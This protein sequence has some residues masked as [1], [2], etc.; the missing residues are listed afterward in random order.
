M[1][2]YENAWKDIVQPM[3]IKSKKHMLGPVQRTINGVRIVRKDL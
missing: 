1:D 2:M 3:Q